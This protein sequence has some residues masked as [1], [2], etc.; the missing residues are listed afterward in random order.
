MMIKKHF[1][2]IILIATVLYLWL[3]LGFTKN[4][5]RSLKKEVLELYGPLQNRVQSI[6]SKPSVESLLV[7]P[8]FLQDGEEEVIRS[9][10]KNDNV[11]LI[12]GDFNYR[13]PLWNWIVQAEKRGFHNWVVVCFDDGKL[14]AWLEKRLFTCH[15]TVPLRYITSWKN[16]EEVEGSTCK[17]Q[18]GEVQEGV[19][20]LNACMEAVCNH[21]WN[22]DCLGVAYNKETQ[23]CTKCVGDPRTDI[24]SM[25]EKKG[26]VVRVSKSQNEIWHL[27]WKAAMDIFNLGIHVLFC[28]L[29]AILIKDPF[30]IFSESG[31]DV[32]AQKG[33]LPRKIATL[34]G[35]SVCMGFTYWKTGTQLRHELIRQV[36]TILQKTGD[37]QS[38]IANA[39]IIEQVRFT[40]RLGDD[41]IVRLGS[42]PRGFVTAILPWRFSP[43]KCRSVSKD[44]IV[45]HCIQ[46]GSAR[47]KKKRMIGIGVW[48]LGHSWERMLPAPNSTAEEYFSSD[49]KI[50][51]LERLQTHHCRNLL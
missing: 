43:R 46:G 29:D 19:P 42:S 38:A 9:R 47:Q 3:E 12:T 15:L 23:T 40:P 25:V 20:N 39:M 34:W 44:M 27:R 7:R 18:E 16:V 13:E 31:A 2:T 28:D 41:K 36:E 11:I 21:Y 22:T 6:E 35:G 30:P 50:W 45:A 49:W 37:D 24:L 17:G 51:I 1:P 14:K 4:E 26:L 8:S 33:F 5:V 32:V 48:S 10:S